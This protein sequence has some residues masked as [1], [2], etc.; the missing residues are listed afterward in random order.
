MMTY[1]C[2]RAGILAATITNQEASELYAEA[3]KHTASALRGDLGT[4]FTFWTLSLIHEG[5]RL[6][7]IFVEP[8]QEG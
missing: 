8:L 4:G 2:N 7:H 6:V 1:L 5:L 3:S